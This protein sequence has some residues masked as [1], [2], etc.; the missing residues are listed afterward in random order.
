MGNLLFLNTLEN[1]QDLLFEHG[2]GHVSS[3]EAKIMPHKTDKQEPCWPQYLSTALSIRVPEP[4]I[5]HY[6]S[7][8]TNAGR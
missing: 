5:E 6:G 2:P 8:G 1:K 7:Q 3:T 4:L